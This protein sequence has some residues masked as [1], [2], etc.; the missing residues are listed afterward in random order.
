MDF[1]HDISVD[2]VSHSAYIGDLLARTAWKLQMVSVN[3]T[4]SKLLCG[5]STFTNFF[6]L[7]F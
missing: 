1:P 3:L 7:M 5:L 2:S 4:G 6:F